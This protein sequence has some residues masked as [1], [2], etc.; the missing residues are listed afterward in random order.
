VS[1]EIQMT[2]STPPT[3]STRVI[4]GTARSGSSQCQAEEITTASTDAP[5]SGMSSP[6]P[7]S[8]VA[9]GQLA[10]RT[11]RIRWSGSTATMLGARPASI[12]VT[13]PVPAARSRTA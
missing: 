13:A 4:S 3:R 12:L 10:E 6:W 2:P 9:A 7:A 11:A 8:T 1:L 5:G